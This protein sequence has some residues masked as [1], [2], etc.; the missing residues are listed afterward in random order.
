[1]SKYLYS[2]VYEEFTGLKPPEPTEIKQ[3][4][5]RGYGHPYRMRLNMQ[6]EAETKIQK[7][8]ERRNQFGQPIN[9]SRSRNRDDQGHHS[10][11]RQHSQHS[12]TQDAPQYEYQEHGHRE[13]SSRNNSPYD[14]SHYKSYQKDDAAIG[15]RDFQANLPPQFNAGRAQRSFRQEQQQDQRQ[16]QKPNSQGASRYGNGGMS[17]QFGARQDATLSQAREPASYKTEAVI[18]KVTYKKRRH[19]SLDADGHVTN[20]DSDIS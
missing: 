9:S 7:K 20:T 4:R 17:R 18:P 5:K 13:Q 8:P 10:D 16:G 12:P 6:E 2:T 11:I 3:R 15:N 14:S 19:V 1:M